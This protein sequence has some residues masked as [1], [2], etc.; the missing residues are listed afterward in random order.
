MSEQASIEAIRLFIN[1]AR[2]FN[3]ECRYSR[4]LAP[5]SRAVSLAEEINNPE[6]LVSAL[7]AE[8]IA[9]RLTGDMAAALVRSSRILAMAE[10]PVTRGSLTSSASI[11]IIFDAHIHWI[12]AAWRL[13]DFPKSELLKFIDSTEQWLRDIGHLD[14]RTPVLTSRAMIQSQL[15][16]LDSAIQSMEEALSLYNSKAPGYFLSTYHRDIG[17]YLYRVSRFSEAEAHFNTALE[18]PDCNDFERCI[19][20]SGLAQC[21]SSTGDTS[22]ALR[23]SDSSLSLAE[24]LGD[25]LVAYALRCR[26]KVLRAAEDSTAAWNFAIRELEAAQRIGL[27]CYLYYAVRDLVDVAL[28][29]HNLD[30]ARSYLPD[31]DRYAAIEDKPL[32]RSFYADAT[33]LRHQRL[34]RLSNSD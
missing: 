33:A 31:L 11:E 2:A 28:D 22:T 16:E 7:S 25:T 10:D 18:L 20:L 13:S 27:N 26:V 3:S 8:E 1:E 19:V 9:L 15:G 32:G 21:A 30:S 6:W 24:Q 29:R 23:H 4:A 14:W 17:D 12:D 34:A 5:A